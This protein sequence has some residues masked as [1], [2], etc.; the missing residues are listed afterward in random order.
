MSIEGGGRLV[1]NKRSLIRTLGLSAGLA[2][3]LFL[4]LL[5]Q[6]KRTV[7]EKFANAVDAL[8]MQRGYQGLVLDTSGSA[9]ILAS[10]LESDG[11]V[12]V[13][14]VRILS[15]EKRLLERHFSPAS[16]S[17]QLLSLARFDFERSQN[18]SYYSGGC[19]PVVV[20]I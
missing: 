3:L 8:E 10:L 17:F 1:I 9:G 7:V 20:E 15:R 16:G 6:S 18:G 5:F 12:F 2:M 14:D 13:S 4:C 19:V 11:K